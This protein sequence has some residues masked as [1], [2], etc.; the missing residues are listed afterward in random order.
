MRKKAPANWHDWAKKLI[1]SDEPSLRSKA[2][3]V[4]GSEVAALIKVFDWASTPLGPI[5]DWPESRRAAIGLILRAAI[6]MATLWGPDGVMIYN[7][8]YATLVGDRHP[9]LLGA[10]YRE[11][12]AEVAAFA[13]QT[14]QAGLAGE[15]LSYRDEGLVLIRDG[16]PQQVWRNLDFSPLIDEQGKPVGVLAVVAD[17][18][19]KVRAE[20]KLE[21]ERRRLRQMFEQA[22]GMIAML[23]G[24]RHVFTLANAALQRFVGREVLGLPLAEALPE[25]ARQGFTA[26]LD[27]ARRTGRP[28]IGR[29]VP[30]MLDRAPGA[31]LIERHVDF[32]FQ[33]ITDED[34]TVNGIF[35]ESHD[36]SDRHRGEDSLRESEARFRLIAESAPVML[37]M[38]DPQGRCVYINAALRGF[39]GIS[40][41]GAAACDWSASLHPEDGPLVRATME[42]ALREHAALAVE[43]RYRRADGRY[44][45]LSTRAHPRFGA[46][47]AFL[48]MIGV[49]V[50]LTDARRDAA[51]AAV[52]NE[53]A[54]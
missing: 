40:T 33:P 31:A 5:D 15:S 22:P 14:L 47:N 41:E 11:A 12:W 29:G 17:T 3:L 27:E 1:P 54:R 43:A 9:A 36:V 48:G 39:W 7:D 13:D 25:V 28:L 52:K 8:A 46:D 35:L 50:D 4:G 20:I 38:S 19:A 10:K 21:G 49:N 16:K 18:T 51:A 6:P 42:R 23:E 32:V 30:L 44:R 37:W 45:L 34:G 2:F 53:L 24:P 26:A